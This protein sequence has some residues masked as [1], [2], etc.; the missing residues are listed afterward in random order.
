MTNAREL[1][2]HLADLLRNER[3][4]LAEFI[5]ALAEF[6]HE[7]RWVD[8]GH[9]SLFAFLSRDLGLSKGA[10]FYR[11]TAARL[12]QQHPAVI[13][14]L[15][16]GRLCLTNVVELA[17]VLTAANLPEVLPR[18]FHLSKLEAKEVVAEL[19]PTPAP[20]RTVVTPISSAPAT[21]RAA[22]LTPVSWLDEPTHANS[23]RSTQEV[24]TKSE[25]EPV[26]APNA[27]APA[28]PT[29]VEPKTADLSRFHVTV[30]RELLRK[31]DAARDALSHSHPGASDADILEAALDLLL[32]RDAKRKGL[33]KKPRATVA[34]EAKRA[35]EGERESRYIPA[36]VRRAVWRRDGGR[37]Q[38]PLE[39]GGVCGS[40]FRVQ[41]HHKIPWAKGGPTTVDDLMCACDFHNDLAARRDFGDAV[42]D[43]YTDG[44]RA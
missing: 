25:G 19:S 12:V 39:G 8:L 20:T 35:D 42:M 10:A 33:V 43:R 3:H 30:S 31:L 22:S 21:A 16:D 24:S 4:A 6:D 15:R 2:N 28:A 27:P 9:K 5:L 44:P 41:L 34:P 1:S 7:R 38:W 36:H 40:T 23:G 14:P 26:R 32:E 37:C 17:K 13:E 18:F 11:M 29:V